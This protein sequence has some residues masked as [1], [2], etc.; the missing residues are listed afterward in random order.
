MITKKQHFVTFL[1]PGTFVH[2]E[3]TNPIDS[4]D[5]DKAV[6]MSRKIVERHNA[7]PFAF[8]F[9]TKGRGESDLD[10]KE[11][12]CSGRYYLGG[13]VMSLDQV[14]RKMPNETTL[15]WNMEV[16]GWKNIVINTNSW[17]ITQP[18]EDD[19]TVI[20]QP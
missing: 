2:E 3:T 7:K 10:S 5:V 14:K 9:S 4:W 13:K 12:N 11:I 6:K 1:S 19:D 15:I 20:P 8:F 18:L 17:K 16:N